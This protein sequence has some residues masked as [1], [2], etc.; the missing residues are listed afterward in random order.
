MASR[1]GD[2]RSRLNARDHSSISVEFIQRDDIAESLDSSERD[3]WKYFTPALFVAGRSAFDVCHGIISDD[4]QNRANRNRRVPH[5]KNKKA[6]I[7]ESSSSRLQAVAQHRLWSVVGKFLAAEMGQCVYRDASRSIPLQPVYLHSAVAK[8]ASHIGGRRRIID[9][10]CSH[11]VAPYLS[12]ITPI[13]RASVPLSV[14]SFASRRRDRDSKITRVV[15]GAKS[16]V[17]PNRR[18]QGYK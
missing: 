8:I 17:T 10:A 2:S 12:E 16:R 5:E 11:G 4:C 13:G 7:G 6:G 14:R 3:S 15:F 1:H 18:G 9:G